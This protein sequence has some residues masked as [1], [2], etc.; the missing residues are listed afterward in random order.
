MLLPDLQVVE[1]VVETHDNKNDDAIQN[2]H[3]L[4]LGSNLKADEARSLNATVLSNENTIEGEILG[5]SRTFQNGSSWVDLFVQDM[6]N[7]SNWDDVRG[8]ATMLLEAFEKNVI[9]NSM[10]SKEE[11]GL[12]KEHLQCVLKDNNI[13]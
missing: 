7:V 12:L 2:L 4:C 1:L 13:L 11:I 3:A 8:K 10:T 9:D 5:N 6:H